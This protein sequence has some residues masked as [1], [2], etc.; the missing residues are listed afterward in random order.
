M[1]PYTSASKNTLY[2][3]LFLLSLKGALPLAVFY[4]CN[5]PCATKAQQIM[6]L[7]FHIPKPQLGIADLRP[8]VGGQIV[9]LVQIHRFCVPLQKA[10]EITVKGFRHNGVAVP[11]FSQNFLDARF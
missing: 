10:V 9:V 8:A 7:S 6:L 5:K 11:V 1:N 2:F 3:S 4:H